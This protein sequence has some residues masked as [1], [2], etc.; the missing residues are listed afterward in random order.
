LGKRRVSR[1]VLDTNIIISA[2]ISPNGVSAKIV[3]AAI[4]QRFEILVHQR[5]LDEI[6]MTTAYPK[7]ASR[8]SRA[9]A[10]R[11]IN[12]MADAAT[13][14]DRLP[15]VMR[16]TDPSDDFLLALA[17]A[18][19]ADFLVTGDKRDLIALETHGKTKIISARHF[20]DI[21]RL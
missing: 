16:S 11:L 12:E 7:I 20:T 10:G 5:L 1:V 13:F 18:G 15:N 4:T 2:L 19:R 6:R 17:E 14:I 21:L 8:I 3:A 9:Q